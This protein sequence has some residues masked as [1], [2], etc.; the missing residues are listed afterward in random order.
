M[1]SLLSAILFTCVSTFFSCQKCEQCT[2]TATTDV[3]GAG[4]QTSTT[5]NDYCGSTLDDIKAN[6]T[7][8]KNGTAYSW[9]CE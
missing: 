8:E 2:L 4:K 6:S 9:S 1:K 3:S 7:Y 5:I